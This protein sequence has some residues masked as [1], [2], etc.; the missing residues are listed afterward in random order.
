MSMKRFEVLEMSIESI[1]M[2]KPLVDKIERKDKKLGGQIKEAMTSVPGNIAE[3][4]HSKG[5]SR[6]SHFH[7]AW[8]SNDEARVH[9]RSAEA[10]GYV[11]EAEVEP[12]EQHMD[13]VSGSLYR[14]TH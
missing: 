6:L 2:A 1:R 11:T 8:G 9:F 14:L 3:G 5:G 10:W 12:L 4:N 7:I 13:K